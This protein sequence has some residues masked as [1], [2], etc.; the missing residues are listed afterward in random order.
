MQHL[1]SF[2]FDKANRTLPRTFEQGE[3]VAKVVQEVQQ[4][5]NN[6]VRTAVASRERRMLHMP[7]TLST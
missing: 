4:L 7:V 1:S 5:D 6:L 2:P 3:V